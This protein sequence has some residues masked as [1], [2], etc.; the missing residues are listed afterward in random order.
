M[1]TSIYSYLTV[2][3]LE[4]YTGIDYEANNTTYTDLVV[5]AKIT[6]AERMVNAYLGVSTGQTVTDGVK[7]ATMIIAAHLMATDME[8]QATNSPI[9]D[10]YII[11]IKSLLGFWLDNDQSIGVDAI[12]MSGA[13]R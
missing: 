8:V 12:P 13:D 9:S 2:T 4:A 11:N 3:E 7:V 1:T 5:E 10:R 6:I